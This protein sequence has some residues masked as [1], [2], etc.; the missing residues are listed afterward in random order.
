VPVHAQQK[1][2]SNLSNDANAMRAELHSSPIRSVCL[3][4]PLAF[5]ESN[6]EAEENRD[7]I[8][9]RGPCFVARVQCTQRLESAVVR[10]ESGAHTFISSRI[11]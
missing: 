5:N 7:G 1:I 3:F 9:A 8:G 2:P 4:F 11:Q 6:L 10:T